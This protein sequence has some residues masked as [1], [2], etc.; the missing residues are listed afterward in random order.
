MMLKR[1]AYTLLTLSLMACN[2]TESP[3]ELKWGHLDGQS[4]QPGAPQFL[5]NQ[6]PN[7]LYDICLASYLIDEL[8]GVESEL[9]AAI[10]VWATAIGRH[11]P[12]N[13]VVAEQERA[14]LSQSANQLM[15][16]YYGNCPAS[17]D[18]VVGL[19]PFKDA[20]TGQT[21][22]SWR[23]RGQEIISFQ[24]Y[25]FLR[26]MDLT[27]GRNAKR[28]VSLAA[29][30][31]RPYS[32]D[33]LLETLVNEQRIVFDPPGTSL[34]L[35]VIVHEVGHIWGLCDQYTGVDN[36]NPQHSSP[37]KDESSIMAASGQL[38]K[39]YLTRD[40]RVGI[41]KL[42]Q[43]EGFNQQWPET[44]ALVAEDIDFEEND[45]LYFA[46][47]DIEVSV[48]SYLLDFGVVTKQSGG[49]LDIEY[50]RQGTDGDWRVMGSIPSAKAF[51]YPQY[52]YRINAPSGLEF[53]LTLKLANDGVPK[54]QYAP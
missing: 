15:K 8:P 31:G 51:N 46:F 43:R 10:N 6:A 4:L 16:T 7:D 11:I 48:D 39:L 12:V 2:P 28:W 40:D 33:E 29:L 32:A 30:E 14:Q 50:R 52:S 44:T 1:T 26:D 21:G 20:T 22:A 37:T 42:V 5:I 41:R 3:T 25:L 24:R 54:Y 49:Q 9:E 47:R 34:S 36:C 53:R 19:A 38:S 17:T 27:P 45:L 35:P 13:I 23:I 18:L